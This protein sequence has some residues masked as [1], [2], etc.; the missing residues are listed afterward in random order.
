MPY[1]RHNATSNKSQLQ[2]E[3]NNQLVQQFLQQEIYFNQLKNKKEIENLD[4]YVFDFSVYGNENFVAEG[5]IIHNTTFS[6]NLLL[7]WDALF[8]SQIKLLP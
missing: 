5:L 1:D 6:D 8:Q 7:C 4:G 3:H 2:L